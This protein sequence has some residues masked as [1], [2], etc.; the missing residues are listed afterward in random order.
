MLVIQRIPNR[1]TPAALSL[2]ERDTLLANSEERRWGRRRARTS[3]GREVAL[4]LPTGTTLE[5]GTIL[6]VEADWYLEVEAALEAVIALCPRDRN[7]AIR[8]AFE[9]GNHHFPLALD[10]NTLLVPD[11]PAM[12]HLL[13]RLGE[14]WEPCQA[15]F[16]PIGKGHVHER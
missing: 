13:D 14:R 15:I 2:K 12:R 11:D 10:G 3:A 5:P 8:I 1:V 16:N 6:A 7:S 4:A 9:V